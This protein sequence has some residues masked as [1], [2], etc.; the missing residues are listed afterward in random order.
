VVWNDDDEKTLL[1]LIGKVEEK[2]KA[3]MLDLRSEPEFDDLSVRNQAKRFSARAGNGVY[4]ALLHLARLNQL[5]NTTARK[6]L[7]SPE[8]LSAILHNILTE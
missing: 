6:L 1:Y 8:N 4:A 3:I 7:K 2:A 5:N